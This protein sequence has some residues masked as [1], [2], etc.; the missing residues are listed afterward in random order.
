MLPANSQSMDNRELVSFCFRKILGREPDKET[1]DAY[2][3]ALNV[4]QISRE[5]LLIQFVLSEEFSQQRR[6]LECFPP[7]HYYSVL[8]SLDDREK[9]VASKL[10]ED[11][12]LGININ[13]EKQFELLK[14]FREYYSQCPFQDKKGS[15]RYYYDNP[16]YPYM[17]GLTLYSMMLE[18]KPKKIIEIGSG[19][20]SSLMLDMNELFFDE[21]IDFT[22]IEP[23]PELLFSLLKES[24]RRHKILPV[25]IQEVDTDIFKALEA[26]DILFIDSTHVSKLKSDVNKEI[27]EILPVLQKGV[28]VHFHDIPCQ[29]EY[30]QDWIKNG[31]AW[32]EAYLLRAFL[33]FNESFEIIFFSGYLHKNY[34]AW[35]KDNMPLSQKNGGDNIWFRRVKV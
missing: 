15:L 26:N 29:F 19:F 31:I 12:L 5:D 3:H 1:S 27:H 11:E 4:N 2:T 16:S 6:N 9:F 10:T 32:N 21:Q 28:L 8:P 34:G 24:D 17:D 13:D 20:S 7:G 22:F 33:E 14:R 23:F 18:F 30:P 35:L 25:K